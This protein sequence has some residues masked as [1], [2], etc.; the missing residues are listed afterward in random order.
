MDAL[1]KWMIIRFP[2][3]IPTHHPTKMDVLPKTVVQIILAAEWLVRFHV[4]HP[5]NNSHN[6][7]LLL[8]L[9]SSSIYGDAT[10]P[11]HF[12]GGAV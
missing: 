3:C 1:K 10:K 7:C 6:L 11:G 2:P 5:P 9:Y 12:S 8:C 4:Q